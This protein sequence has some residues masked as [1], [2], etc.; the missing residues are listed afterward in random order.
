MP[1]IHKRNCNYCGKYYEGNG[2]KY[3]SNECRHKSSSRRHEFNCKFCNKLV[4]R[5]IS[6]FKHE[7]PTYCSHKCFYQ[8]VRENKV[9]NRAERKKENC[10]NCNKEII[11]RG[12]EITSDKKYCSKKCM[13]EYRKGWIG[14]KNPKYEPDKH[15]NKKCLWC[16]KEFSIHTSKLKRNRGDGNFC[17]RQCT[18]AYVVRYRQNRVSLA[19]KEIEKVFNSCNMNFISQAK[20]GKFIADFYFPDKNIIVEFD[21]VY[22]H[23]LPKIIEKDKR[24]EKYYLENGYKLLR[25]KEED[26]LKNKCLT[27]SNIIDEINR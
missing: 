2:K 1:T 18:G 11:L 19:E 25:I 6:S 27:L 12:Y 7:N 4:S 20:I 13:D 23:S 5:A 21:G 9:L 14:K 15:T 26:Y 22:W 17:S 24:K 3:C 16:D 10:L 8:D